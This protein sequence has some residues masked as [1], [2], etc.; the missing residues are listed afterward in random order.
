MDL[1][2]DIDATHEEIVFSLKKLR[3]IFYIGEGNF[4]VDELAVFDR[5]EVS[6]FNLHF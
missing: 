5:M 6:F 3:T 2:V 4:T 1:E